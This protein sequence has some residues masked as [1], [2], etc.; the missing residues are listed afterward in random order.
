[1][2]LRDGWTSSS[3]GFGVLVFYSC[4]VCWQGCGG[5]SFFCRCVQALLVHVWRA[6]GCQ[7]RSS[8]AAISSGGWLSMPPF[9]LLC[10]HVRG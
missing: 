1:M 10:S 7:L 4:K 8:C 9:C 3:M 6:S 2:R 5:G